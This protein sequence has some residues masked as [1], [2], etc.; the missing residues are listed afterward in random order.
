MSNRKQRREYL[1]S[2]NTPAKMDEYM[3][4][5]EMR[6]RAYYDNAYRRDMLK[7]VND[8]LIAIQYTLHF[9]ENTKFGNKRINDFMNDLLVVV[10]GFTKGEY[11]PSEYQEILA[12][13]KISLRGV[14][15]ESK[16]ESN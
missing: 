11:S 14:K 9:N 7:S 12:K 2:L 8:F 15:Y 3:K 5:Y 4:G 16:R 10:E 6:I 1:R 13:E